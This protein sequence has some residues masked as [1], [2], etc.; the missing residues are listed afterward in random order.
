ME[1]RPGE[2]TDALLSLLSRPVVTEP[3]VTPQAW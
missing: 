2:V 1:E 3:G